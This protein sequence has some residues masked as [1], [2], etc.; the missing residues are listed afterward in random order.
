MKAK[1]VAS[2]LSLLVFV[3]CEDI[4]P[5]GGSVVSRRPYFWPEQVYLPTLGVELAK[6]VLKNIWLPAGATL[7]VGCLVVSLR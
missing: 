6:C 2:I 1:I 7:T 5:S 4:S 3:A